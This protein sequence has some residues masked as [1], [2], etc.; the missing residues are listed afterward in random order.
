MK[1]FTLVVVGL[2][3]IKTASYGGITAPSSYLEVSPDETRILVMLGSPRC[4]AEH[5]KPVKL[6]DGRTVDIRKQFSNS[7]IY[8]IK[9]FS[10]ILEIDWFAF[11]DDLQWNDDFSAIAILNRFGLH[12]DPAIAFARDGKIFRSYDC[13]FL[14]TSLRHDLFLSF[15][16]WDWHTRWYDEFELVDSTLHVSTAERQIRRRKLGLQEF[17]EFDFTTGE[18]IS[19]RVENGRLKGILWCIG[20]G[21][22]GIII[23]CGIWVWL[24]SRRIRSSGP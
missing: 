7:G 24:S 23:A 18:L 14:L 17:Y 8:D 19:R 12:S 15:S 1:L 22:L 3:S 20:F 6:P 5:L 4:D 10:P 16:T 21:L 11:S 13:S 2:L 9:T